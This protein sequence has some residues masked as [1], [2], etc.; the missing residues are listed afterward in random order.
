ML[1]SQNRHYLN[2]ACGDIFID[3]HHWVNIDWAP[4]NKRIKKRNLLKPLTF[5]DNYFD[6]IY[7][8]H[9]VEHISRDNVNLFLAEMKRLLKVNGVLRIAVPDFEYLCRLYIEMLDSQEYE[10][11]Q[12]VTS[13]ILDQCV[14][15]KS[16][17]LIPHW[18]DR[19]ISR[20][21]LKEFITE[22]NGHMFKPRPVEPLYWFKFKKILDIRKVYGKLQKVYIG[23]IL[24]LLPDSFLKTQVSFTEPGENHAWVY[25]FYTLKE[26]L[27][28]VGFTKVLKVSAST[29]NFL[30]FPFSRLDIDTSGSPIK[31][32]ESMYVEAIG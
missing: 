13:Q 30:N 28:S 8:S 12:F 16:G 14:R 3:D 27:L 29:S 25:D 22:V 24:N 10:K 7:V 23:I 26:H 15:K 4:K 20:P 19:A 21:D 1:E 11:S 5:P 9:F 2:V 18:Y 17:G 6:L 31:G 32:N